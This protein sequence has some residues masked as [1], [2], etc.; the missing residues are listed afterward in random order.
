MGTENK[1][2]PEKNDAED[3]TQDQKEVENTNPLVI[4]YIN[5]FISIL[6]R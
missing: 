5:F 4:C 1:T 3:N 6:N 2:I